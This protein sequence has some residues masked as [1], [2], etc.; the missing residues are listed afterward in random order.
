MKKLGYSI[1][2]LI[3]LLI[4]A[5]VFVIVPAMVGQGRPD[6]NAITF[7]KYNGKEI[8]YE[9]NSKLMSNIQQYGQYYQ[10]MGMKVD[11][12]NRFYIY[13]YA[14]NATVAEMAAEDEV[15]KSG[16]TVPES[17][18]NRLLRNY[19]T[20]EN[21]KFS[22]KLYNQTPQ[23]DVSNMVSEI[24][25]SLLSERFNSDNFGSRNEYIGNDALYGL[26]ASTA[27]LDFL[28]SFD[29]S[30]R[31]FNM[32]QFSLSDYPDEE[33]VAYGKAHAEKFIKY[34]MS[35]ITTETEA[36][37]KKVLK[38]LNAEEITFADAVQE[39]S[40]KVYGNSEGKLTASYAYQL[41]NIIEDN[42]DFVLVS[43]LKNG[44]KSDVVKTKMGYAVFAC[45]GDSVAADFDHE[46]LTSV[47]ASYLNSYETGE[48]ENYFIAKGNTFI[49]DA[50]ANGF[51]SAC[52][53]AGVEKTEITPF[54]LN[55]GNVS[56]AG[57]LTTNVPGLYDAAKNEDFLTKAFSLKMNECSEPSV[58]GEYVVILQYVSEDTTGSESAAV[59]AELPNMDQESAS[60]AIM[61]S[62]KL[63]NNFTSVYISNMM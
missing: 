46:D 59:L 16:Y 39:Y 37:A 48:I 50:K 60:N 42:G 29:S 1:G 19:F 32:V 27:E 6:K 8:R 57:K 54:P 11:D 18:V 17:T 44:A 63:E 52:E 58:V 40:N 14:F 33:K 12:S 35:V 36:D 30:K 4:C 2:T 10:N 28:A 45:D 31:G 3:I 26:K 20:D 55:Y 53:K 7:G 21:G 15:K 47:V 25:E 41:E 5:F 43:Q 13:N 62:P 23:D 9:P 49:A 61:N 51:D 34:D 24:K 22:E 56:L 38:R